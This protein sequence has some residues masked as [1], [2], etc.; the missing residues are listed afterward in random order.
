MN[1]FICSVSLAAIIILLSGKI[2]KSNFL[3]NILTAGVIIYSLV[4]VLTIKF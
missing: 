4:T 3:A 2:K 1:S